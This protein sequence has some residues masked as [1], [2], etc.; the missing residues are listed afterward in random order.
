M[1]LFTDNIGQFLQQEEANLSIDNYISL[2]TS[3][4]IQC[5]ID[6]RTNTVFSDVDL[7]L[8]VP[9]CIAV[10]PYSFIK[11]AVVTRCNRANAAFCRK[12][13]SKLTSPVDLGR[14]F[15][16]GLLESL[17]LMLQSDSLRMCFYCKDGW[18]LKK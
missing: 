5:T 12:I 17:L 8:Q 3:L 2:V 13:A 1:H 11:G 6:L 18:K 10:G 9:A 14:S 15:L 7:S 16:D 4:T